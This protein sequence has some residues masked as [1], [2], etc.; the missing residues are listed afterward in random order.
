MNE[1]IKNAFDVFHANVKF[2]LVPLSSEMKEHLEELEDALIRDRVDYT[3]AEEEYHWGQGYDSGFSDGYDKG[4]EEGYDEGYSE[5]DQEIEDLKT[6][7]AEYR[8][9]VD[10]LRKVNI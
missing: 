5:C 6:E 2:G 3:E 9:M 10:D 1:S 8:E 7:I 4:K